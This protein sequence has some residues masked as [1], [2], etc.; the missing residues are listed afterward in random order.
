MTIMK[1]KGQSNVWRIQVT[2]PNDPSTGRRHR[3]SEIFRGTKSEAKKRETAL[4]ASIDRG[5]HVSRKTGTLVE[6]VNVWWPTK[7]ASIRP[8]TADAYRRLLDGVVLP[9]LG[10]HPIQKITTAQISRVIGDLVSRDRAGQAQHVHIFLGILF[11]SAV[12]MGE[13]AKNPVL[14][15]DRPTVPSKEM[16]VL[17]PQDW[18]RVRS[19]MESNAPHFLM[20]FTLLITSGVRRGELSGFQW[21]DIDFTRGMVQVRRSVYVAPG[22]T[23]I[24]GEPKTSAGRRTIALDKGTMAML[25]KHRYEAEYA[26]TMFERRVTPSDWV[27]PSASGGPWRPHSITDAWRRIATKLDLGHI[28]CHDLRH[29]S[30]SL[31][32]G[33]GVPVQLVSARLGHHS[34]GFTLSTYAHT[35]P[36]QQEIAAEALA[37]MLNDAKPDIPQIAAH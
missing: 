9:H 25:Q 19:Y 24:V 1:H 31:L 21:R 28:R 20:A 7:A 13:I 32:I 17:S 26:A 18:E 23:V 4:K 37:A 11:N 6:F 22:G 2:A 5:D 33:A 34:A 12:R 14:G 27:F 3:P 16:R 30:A 15:V 29:S 10:D 8:S 36:G 35:L